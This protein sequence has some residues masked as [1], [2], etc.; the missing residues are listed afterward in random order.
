LNQ[1]AFFDL[2][3][4]A[5]FLH[6]VVTEVEARRKVLRDGEL[7]AQ[8]EVQ[9]GIAVVTETVLAALQVHAAGT[10]QHERHEAVFGILSDERAAVGPDRRALVVTSG[11]RRN[12]AEL[13]FDAEPREGVETG[14]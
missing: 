1:V 10:D 13:A 6:Q 11:L 3:V 9:R 5:I 2:R 12:D 14:A 7:R 8:P 4:E